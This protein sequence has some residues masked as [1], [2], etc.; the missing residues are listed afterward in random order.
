[1]SRLGTAILCASIVLIAGCSGAS[2]PENVAGVRDM[3]RSIGLDA[4]AGDFTDVC[5][6]YMNEPLRDQVERSNDNCSTANSTSSLERWAEKVR[7][8]K[9]GAGTR[10]VVSGNEALVYDGAK[11]ERA[12]YVNGQ[13][14]LAEV[15]ELTQ[16]RLTP[17]H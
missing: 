5:R 11:P 7:L 14:L 15:P 3:Y 2:A 17:R 9:V 13:W 4:G 6:S 12:L 1:M 8:A 10:I 16:S